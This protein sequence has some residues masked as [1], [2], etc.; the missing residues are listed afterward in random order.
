MQFYTS[1]GSSSQGD[2][3][4]AYRKELKQWYAN[5]RG[6]MQRLYDEI[7]KQNF[8]RDIEEVKLFNTLC[9]ELYERKLGYGDIINGRHSQ[10]QKIL[11]GEAGCYAKS[12]LES[13]ESVAILREARNP[14]F[15]ILRRSLLPRY[16]GDVSIFTISLTSNENPYS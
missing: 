11:R 9:K 6:E 10:I 16:A 3:A 14:T 13:I 5:N 15:F 2:N 7:L 4:L 12:R 1:C 8:A